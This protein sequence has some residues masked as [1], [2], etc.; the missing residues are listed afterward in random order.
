M[1]NEERKEFL[2]WHDDLQASLQEGVLKEKK[3]DHWLRLT[4]RPAHLGPAKP[5]PKV[6]KMN[7]S[8]WT[9]IIGKRLGWN[10]RQAVRISQV[11]FPWMKMLPPRTIGKRMARTVYPKHDKDWDDYVKEIERK[12]ENLE[13]RRRERHAE[14]IRDW[15]DDGGAEGQRRRDEAQRRLEE[16]NVLREQRNREQAQRHRNEEFVRRYT[17]YERYLELTRDLGDQERSAA[18]EQ[19][20]RSKSMKCFRC[21]KWGHKANSCTNPRAPRGPRGNRQG[22]WR[23]MRVWH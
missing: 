20:V 22:D 23:Q 16:E 11:I 17:E 21:H 3:G 5:L 19:A 12:E 18:E 9:A 6:H 2:K 15:E 7:Y 10:L 4:P 8:R 1:T 14:E 13:R